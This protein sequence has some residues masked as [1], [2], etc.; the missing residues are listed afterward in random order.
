M[1]QNSKTMEVQAQPWRAGLAQ[2]DKMW[3]LLLAQAKVGTAARPKPWVQVQARSTFKWRLGWV[4]RGMKSLPIPLVLPARHITSLSLPFYWLHG[5]SLFLILFRN[6]CGIMWFLILGRCTFVIIFE[7]TVNL[8]VEITSFLQNSFLSVYEI[9][10][11]YRLL[12]ANER[13]KK[14]KN[15]NCRH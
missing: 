6:M 1:E 5:M 14:M 8:Y 7:I 15:Q 2:K 3:A 9:E 13:G 11:D 4:A 10:I 12:W